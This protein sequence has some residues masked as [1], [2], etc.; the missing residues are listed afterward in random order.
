MAIDIISFLGGKIII[1]IVVL[2]LLIIV[3]IVLMIMNKRL[4][5]RMIFKEIKEEKEIFLRN[6]IANLR[7][8]K[9][10]NEVLLNSINTFARNFFREAFLI[11]QNLDYLE[12]RDMF[13]Q[14][15]QPKIALFCHKMLQTLYTGGSTKKEDIDELVGYLEKIVNEFYLAKQGSLTPLNKRPLPIVK[16]QKPKEIAKLPQSEDKLEK[17][18][19]IDEEQ[20]RNAYQEFQIRF[21]Q[22]YLKAEKSKNTQALAKLIELR[23]KIRVT[24]NEYANDNSKIA[25]LTKEISDGVKLIKTII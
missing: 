15:N 12:L 11:N 14:K 24:I 16:Q 13:A 21:R 2:A 20:V 8:A 17:L 22:A 23:D 9:R 19:A 6:E 5:K 7:V 3:A 25:D 18:T 4:K 10:S 1:L